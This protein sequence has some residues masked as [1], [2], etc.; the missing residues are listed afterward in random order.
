MVRDQL[1]NRMSELLLNVNKE[2]MLPRFL[3]PPKRNIFVV[4]LRLGQN[5]SKSNIFIVCDFFRIATDMF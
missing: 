1:H 3:S 4:F 2:I 5:P